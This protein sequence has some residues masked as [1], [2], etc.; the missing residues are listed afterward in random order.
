MR[1]RIA[2]LIA[3]LLASLLTVLGA[4]NALAESDAPTEPTDV[5]GIRPYLGVGGLTGFDVKL[6]DS[7][8]Q[9]CGIGCTPPAEVDPGLGFSLRFGGRSSHV[10]AEIATEMLTGFDVEHSG[11]TLDELD[12]YTQLHVG[13]NLRLYPF[14]RW[15]K[16]IH[17]HVIVG[18]GYNFMILTTLAQETWG[19]N[20][21]VVRAGGG[22]DFD[23]TDRIALSLDSTYVRTF[24]GI[25]NSD[26]VTLGWGLLFRF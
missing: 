6:A 21:G 14:G 9:F 13:A 23:L 25:E 5:T 15:Q 24:G 26:Y 3:I 22:V 16:R 7:I 20:G 10:G 18:G 19:L 4:G 2:R 17:P 1:T 11:P 12:R 8:V